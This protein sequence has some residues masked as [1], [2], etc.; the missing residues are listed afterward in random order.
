M[1]KTDRVS[2]DAL[3][4][5]HMREA[6]IARRWSPFDAATEISKLAQESVSEIRYRQ[7]E[8]ADRMPHISFL[9]ALCAA[10]QVSPQWLLGMPYDEGLTGEEAYFVERLRLIEDPDLRKLVLEVMNRYATLNEKYRAVTG[11]GIQRQAPDCEG[12]GAEAPA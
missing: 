9:P 5:A 8:R 7:W 4:A 3:V 2:F 12:D 11:R 10:L 1:P 6:R